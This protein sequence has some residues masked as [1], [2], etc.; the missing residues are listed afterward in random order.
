[1]AGM[2]SVIAEFFRETKVETQKVSWATRKE[3]LAATYA[4]LI[5]VALS[6][7]FIS[8]ADLASGS[9]IAFLIKAL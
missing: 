6:V 3:I 8:V 2:V 9:L 1:M 5:I 7:V 4:I